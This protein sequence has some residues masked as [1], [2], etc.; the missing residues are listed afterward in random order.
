MEKWGGSGSIQCRIPAV[1]VFP[2]ANLGAVLMALSF[3]I[4]YSCKNLN[5]CTPTVCLK[6]KIYPN[7]LLS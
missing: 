7:R 1:F 5:L 3:G 6:V 4:L 2:A